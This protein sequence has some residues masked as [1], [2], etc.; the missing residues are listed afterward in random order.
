MTLQARRHLLFAEQV[1]ATF[2]AT[3]TMIARNPEIFQR[4]VREGCVANHSLTYV[5][6]SNTP[7]WRTRLELTAHRFGGRH[8]TPGVP[9]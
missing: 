3:G 4:E 8:P 9:Q 1:P 5:D 7:E 2:F 6:A